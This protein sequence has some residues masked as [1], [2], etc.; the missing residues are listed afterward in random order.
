MFPTGLSTT[1]DTA[2]NTVGEGAYLFQQLHLA[3]DTSDLGLA[4]PFDSEL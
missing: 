4:L 3:S 2:S 1:M